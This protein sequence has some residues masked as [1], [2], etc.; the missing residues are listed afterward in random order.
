MDTMRILHFNMRK[1]AYVS[2]LLSRDMEL[3]NSVCGLNFLISYLP[4]IKELEK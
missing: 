3:E 4:T 2:E 1:M